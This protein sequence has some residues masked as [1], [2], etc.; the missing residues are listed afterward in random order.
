MACRLRSF[1]CPLVVEGLKGPLAH[2]VSGPLLL[3]PQEWLAEMV[4]LFQAEIHHPLS[5]SPLMELLLSRGRFFWE[6]KF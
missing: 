6:S 4:T 1:W 5:L 2:L 3:L